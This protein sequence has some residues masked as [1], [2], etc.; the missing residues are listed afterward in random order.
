SC[1]SP[2]LVISGPLWNASLRWIELRIFSFQT[3]RRACRPVS[4]TAQDD[5]Y[6]GEA[7]R[8]VRLNLWRRTPWFLR[9]RLGC[10]RATRSKV[11]GRCLSWFW[12]LVQ[13]G[14]VEVA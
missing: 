11:K 13:A 14:W 2:S 10:E 4:R 5:G 8:E 1:G 7:E 3:R 6:V 12:S 9:S